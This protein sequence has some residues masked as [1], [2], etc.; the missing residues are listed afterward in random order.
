MKKLFATL[1]SP[2]L[3]RILGAVLLALTIWIGGP[4]LA[5]AQWRPLEP[6]W[7]RLTLIILLLALWFGQRAIKAI[8]AKGGIAWSLLG[9]NEG[10]GFA[11]KENI[12][13]NFWASL[14]FWQKT[15]LG[16]GGTK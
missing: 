8:R 16:E 11:K 3:L 1:F 10:H 6:G 15:L 12:D 7:A 13:Y 14:M 4:L 5:F 2:W 9:Q